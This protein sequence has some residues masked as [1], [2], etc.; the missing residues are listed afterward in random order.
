MCAALEPR[1]ITI[2]LMLAERDL[3]AVR[4][5]WRG[6][7]T[8]T[9]KGVA[10]SGWRL[11]WSIPTSIACSTAGFERIGRLLIGSRWQSNSG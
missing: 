4:S 8:G 7:Y 3:V 1:N 9:F 2:D 10:V 11:A 6:A 5:T